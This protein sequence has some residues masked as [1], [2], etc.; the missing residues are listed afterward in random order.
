MK[1]LLPGDAKG[2]P[3][4]MV[5]IDIDGTLL[6]TRGTIVSERN[7]Q[8]LRAAEA[9]GIEIVIATGR[10]QAFAMPILAGVGLKQESILISSNGSITRNFAGDL[11]ERAVL[12]LETAR[13]LCGVLRP[14]GSTVMTFDREGKGSLV[15][16]SFETLH[17]RIQLWVDA[18]R[19]SLLEVV[20]LER[21]LDDGDCPVQAMVCGTMASMRRAEETLA[22]S[23]L[24]EHF[25]LHRTAYPARDLCIVDIL[26]PGC[27]KGAA[28]EKLALS[29][30]LMR[31]QVMAIGDNF[32][33]IEMMEYA[34]SA[35]IM[36]NSA[37]ELL[38]MALERG[39]TVTG[40]NDEDG[41]A[42]VIDSLLVT[43]AP[44]S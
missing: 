19:A 36:A 12:G 37:P 8:A 32:N 30:G 31:E 24:A 44:A 7:R 20:P 1:S 16:E 28:L 11:L 2:V 13:A 3:I 33:D 17:H 39:W 9:A 42:Q 26:P 15:I 5:A 25:E 22:A 38:E 23:S 18:N 40:T 14:F 35:V 27:S 43:A 21:A 10:R 6:P 29:R 34:G 4:R 41:V